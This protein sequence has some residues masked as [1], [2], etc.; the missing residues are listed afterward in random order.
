MK[1]IGLTLMCVLLAASLSALDIKIGVAAGGNISFMT[2][3]DWND[4]VVG[5]SDNSIRFGFEAGAFGNIAINE[6]FS[7]QPELNFLLTRYGTTYNVKFTE[8][9]KMIEI[10]FLAKLNYNDFFI[11]L[12]PALQIIFGDANYNIKTTDG[13][14]IHSGTHE[15]DSKIAFSGVFGVG[16]IVHVGNGAVFIDLRYR[17]QFT[18]IFED[19]N[20]KLNTIAL[21]I[22]YGFD[23]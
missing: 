16:H 23:L 11:F 15:I 10:P 13:K 8:T 18:D 21:R 17:R 22:G 5:S 19:F 12:G 7:I 9:I 2:G 20:A 6:F 14:E 4:Y 1:K 3:S